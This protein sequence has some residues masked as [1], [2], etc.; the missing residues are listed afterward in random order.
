MRTGK[1]LPLLKRNGEPF[2]F[3]GNDGGREWRRR[4]GEKSWP[5]EEMDWKI[6]I[7]H[8]YSG[9]VVVVRLSLKDVCCEDVLVTTPQNDG[10]PKTLIITLS[11]IGSTRN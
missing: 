4:C 9:K 6:G 10:H 5:W 1:C 7:Q 2:V 3:W 11:R 8:V